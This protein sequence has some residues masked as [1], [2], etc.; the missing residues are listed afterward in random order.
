M[1]TI[2]MGFLFLYFVFHLNW[3]IIISFCIGLLGILSSW[4]SGKI[5][6]GWY[7]LAKGMSC[8]MNTILLSLIFYLVLVPIAFLHKIGRKESIVQ[9]SFKDS[10]FSDVPAG[11]PKESFKKPW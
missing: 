6:H 4:I 5:V 7:L 8:V 2:S 11:F 3:F 1:L 10:T 9:S